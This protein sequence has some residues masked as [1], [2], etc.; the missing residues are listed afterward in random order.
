MTK[1]TR[2]KNIE[3]DEPHWIEWVTGTV[4]AVIVIAVMVWIAKD[5]IADR[6]ASP[7]LVGSVARVEPRSGGYQVQFEVR[8]R[9]SVT[10]SQVKVRGEV[11]DGDALLEATETVVDYV[12]GHSTATGGMIFQRD[13]GGKTIHIQATAFNDP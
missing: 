1:T 2:D 4:S 9:A 3:A 6:D 7:D 8:N 12:P 5:A 11:R 10:A 13:P